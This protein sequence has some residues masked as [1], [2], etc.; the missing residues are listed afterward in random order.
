MV[1]LKG[2]KANKWTLM[3]YGNLVYLILPSVTRQLL[4]I[5]ITALMLIVLS[6]FAKHGKFV[7]LYHTLHHEHI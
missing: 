1:T 5:V 7:C 6:N 3:H 2:L 4:K